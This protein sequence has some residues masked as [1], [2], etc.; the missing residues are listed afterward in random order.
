[1]FETLQATLKS[2]GGACSTKPGP[3]V[4][5]TPVNYASVDPAGPYVNCDQPGVRPPSLDEIPQINS[6]ARLW[7]Q[8]P[9]DD[10]PSPTP[11]ISVGVMLGKCGKLNFTS[12]TSGYRNFYRDAAIEKM[13]NPRTGVV[14]VAKN[15]P[16]WFK[17]SLDWVIKNC[18]YASYAGSYGAGVAAGCGLLNSSGGSAQK[19]IYPPGTIT[20]FDAGVNLWHVAVPAGAQVSL[21]GTGSDYEVLAPLDAK[22]GPAQNVQE[23]DLATFKAKTKGSIFKKWWFWAGAGT[24]LVGGL[25]AVGYAVKKKRRQ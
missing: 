12:S 7:A 25:V 19:A 9:R 16:S 8:F 18:Q 24:L 22:P 5:A 10:V 20:S 11:G 2:A 17:Q 15:N 3:I 6:C 4:N 1:M 23:V 14:L 21:A 13:F